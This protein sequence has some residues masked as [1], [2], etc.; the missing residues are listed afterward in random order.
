M[1]NPRTATQTERLSCVNRGAIVSM[2]LST[3]VNQTKT[4]EP[5]QLTSGH[6]SDTCY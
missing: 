6:E 4:I 2:D 3:R 1:L 5:P